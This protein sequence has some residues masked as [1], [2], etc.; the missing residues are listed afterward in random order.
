MAPPNL[1]KDG[2]RLQCFGSGSW[3]LGG[4]EE[5]L[6]FGGGLRTDAYFGSFG[7]DSH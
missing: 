7:Q 5:T 4:G 1:V 6:V 2:G 3:G